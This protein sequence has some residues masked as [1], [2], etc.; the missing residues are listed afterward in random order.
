MKKRL[1]E[2]QEQQILTALDTAAVH[3]NAGDDPNTAMVKA[4]KTHQ[5]PAGHINLMVHAY[6]TARTHQQRVSGNTVLEKAA[7]F[8]LANAAEIL[9]TLYPDEVK[10]AAAHAHA[11]NIS[12]SYAFAPIWCDP[13]MQQEKQAAR[14]VSLAMLDT[15]APE[16]PEDETILAKR[17]WA[18]HEAARQNY[19]QSHRQLCDVKDTVRAAF[20]K[21]ATYFRT[22]G[23]SAFGDVAA[24][25]S[26][27]LG[28]HGNAVMQQVLRL[29]PELEKEA[30]GSL[31]VIIDWNSQPYAIIR[32][33][34]D[35]GKQL[36]Q[37]KQAVDAAAAAMPQPLINRTQH[38]SQSQSCLTGLV[39]TPST[40]QAG[41][42]LGTVLGYDMAKN[43]VRGIGSRLSTSG[44]DTNEVNKQLDAI[45][46]PAQDSELRNIEF[47]YVL[48]DMLANDPIIKQYEPTKVLDAFNEIVQS[49]PAAATQPL[50]L[51][52]LLRKHLQQSA[53]DPFESQ[54][55][56][57]MEKSV[58]SSRAT[59]K[60]HALSVTK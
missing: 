53:F 29:R 27:Y 35:H 17:A 43:L 14:N 31:P 56:A 37:C 55:V 59:G 3:V 42:G 52:G 60:N 11:T 2:L 16:L 34:V 15:P 24:V 18:T 39:N 48:Q 46:T 10:T 7:E 28:R 36:V 38:S 5:I 47:K 4:A 45:S 19:D 8:P 1:T 20:N 22:P 13:E 25:A 58:L 44:P 12:A 40:K 51:R 32:E 33:C 6:N 9:E 30:A 50:Q 23:H 21:L 54:Q 26:Q 57:E 49:A 41:L